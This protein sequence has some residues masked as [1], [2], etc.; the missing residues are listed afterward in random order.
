MASVR[1]MSDID[2]EGGRAGGWHLTPGRQKEMELGMQGTLG[3][4]MKHPIREPMGMFEGQDPSHSRFTSEPQ[5]SN[6]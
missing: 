1:E 6:L 3:T 5:F 4:R 2:S